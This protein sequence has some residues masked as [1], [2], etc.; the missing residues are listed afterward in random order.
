MISSVLT[1]VGSVLG[2]GRAKLVMWLAGLGLLL[3]G[4]LYYRATLRGA[5]RDQEKL[6][7]YAKTLDLIKERQKHDAYY[8]SLSGDDARRRL[9]KHWSRG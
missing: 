8:R 4:L 1:I 3:V 9:R 5:V 2:I 6:R 7:R